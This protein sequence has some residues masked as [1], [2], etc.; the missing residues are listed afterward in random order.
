MPDSP[1]WERRLRRA[2]GDDYELLFTVPPRARGRFR[3]ARPHMG[4]PVTKIGVVTAEPA[5][6]LEGAEAGAGLDLGAL[7]F[8][9][10]RSP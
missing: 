3:A 9:H 5:L 2:L 6:A 8:D 1:L 10:F 4:T 7:G